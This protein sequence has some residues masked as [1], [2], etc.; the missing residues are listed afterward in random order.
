MIT[1]ETHKSTIILSIQTNEFNSFDREFFL[2][3]SKVIEE[4]EKNSKCKTIILTGKNDKYLRDSIRSTYIQLESRDIELL[5][6][7][8]FSPNG[9][10]GLRSILEKRRPVWQDISV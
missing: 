10:E 6:K 4:A 3:L 2:E 8:I 1:K 9:Q 7:A 5:S